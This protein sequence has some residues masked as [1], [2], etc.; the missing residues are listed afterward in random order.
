VIS[1]I[2]YNPISSNASEY[3]ELYN[4]GPLNQDLTGWR[5]DGVGFT[6]TSGTIAS[7]NYIVVAA[8]PANLAS[9]FPNRLTNGLNLFGPFGGNSHLADGGEHLTLS[10]ANAM[11]IDEVAYGDGGR[12]GRWSDGGGSSLELTDLRNDN[13]LAMN[14]ADSDETSKAGWSNTTTSGWIE[15]GDGVSPRNGLEI[16]LEGEGECWVDNVAVIP[17]GSTNRATN[18]NFATDASG[19]SFLG[20]HEFSSRGTN[21][22]DGGYLHLRASGRGDYL[23]NR[24][25]TTLNSELG[26]GTSCLISNRARW[27][28]GN[29]D[30]LL[31]I[32]GNYLESAITLPVPPNL[33]TPGAP[34]SRAAPNAGPAISDVSHL[35]VVPAPGQPVAVSAGVSDPD[36][37]TNVVLK[38]RLDPSGSYSSTNML[39]SGTGGDSV[40]GDGIFTAALPGQVAGSLIAFY[41]QADDR[42]AT[43]MTS[44]FPNDAPARECLVRF[45]EAPA[46]GTMG[47][48]RIWVT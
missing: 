6:F 1:E 3:V 18:G 23:A 14:W 34:N 42:S 28:R 29:P 32:R 36:G 41:P 45:G 19:W 12:W 44:T 39:D 15:L 37:V 38:Y 4:R 40:E 2:M 31:R 16:I 11:V 5:I 21:G 13:R 20:N 46:S 7:S 30:L 10:N 48:Y 25:E 17:Q 27:L 8:N 35:P 33:G 43:N 22:T 24:V 9:N 26:I 47:T